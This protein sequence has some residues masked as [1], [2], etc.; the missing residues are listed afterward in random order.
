MDRQAD[1]TDCFN[2]PANSVGNKYSPNWPRGNFGGML[3]N[4]VDQYDV[5]VLK[6]VVLHMSCFL[7]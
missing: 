4:S 1:A 5:H 3:L 6:L 2:S 7:L